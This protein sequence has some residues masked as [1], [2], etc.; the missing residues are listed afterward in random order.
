MMM[1]TS[2]TVIDHMLPP[3]IIAISIARPVAAGRPPMWSITI[4]KRRPGGPV[5]PADVPA[6]R[7]GR[8]ACVDRMATFAQRA[9]A[10]RTAMAVAVVR[11]RRSII[12]SWPIDDWP[13]VR[14]RCITRRPTVGGALRRRLQPR[15]IRQRDVHDRRR[16]IDWLAV[17]VAVRVTTTAG[18][19]VRIISTK[20]RMDTIVG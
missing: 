11:M 8:P 10:A 13:E 20:V 14:V 18:R 6:G 7:V 15:R 3:I 1:M 17:A 19:R 16:C 9:V 12:S 5:A 2:T 4:A